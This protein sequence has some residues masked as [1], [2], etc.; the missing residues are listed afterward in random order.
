MTVAVEKKPKVVYVLPQKTQLP[1]QMPMATDPLT[2]LIML[3]FMPLLIFMQILS[4][5][6][7]TALP[8]MFPQRTFRRRREYVRD[9][10]GRII[11]EL[12]EVEVA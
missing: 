1:L 5:M 11:E 7:T 3:P 2:M 4:Q 10:S 9:H 8:T 12:E 6:Q